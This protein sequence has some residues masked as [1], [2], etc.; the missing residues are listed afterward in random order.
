MYKYL[1]YLLSELNLQVLKKEFLNSLT[2]FLLDTPVVAQ[3]FKPLFFDT[4]KLNLL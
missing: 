4:D 1:F 2:L 3:A